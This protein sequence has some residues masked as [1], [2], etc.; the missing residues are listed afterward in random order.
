[1]DVKNLDKLWWTFNDSFF[2]LWF[3]LQQRLRERMLYDGQGRQ[4]EA[5]VHEVGLVVHENGRHREMVIVVAQDD[6]QIQ[7][8]LLTMSEKKGEVMNR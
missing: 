4:T 3:H 2:Y 6:Q 7:Q 1:M 8:Q 5:E